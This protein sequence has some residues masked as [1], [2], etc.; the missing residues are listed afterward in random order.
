MSMV[1]R[2]QRRHHSN[3]Q[4]KTAESLIEIEKVRLD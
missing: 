3:I 1:P 2:R 4:E